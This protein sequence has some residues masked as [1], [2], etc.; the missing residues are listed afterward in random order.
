MLLITGFRHVLR[1]LRWHSFTLSPSLALSFLMQLHF[2]SLFRTQSSRWKGIQAC[3]R[4]T[5][6]SKLQIKP[7]VLGFHCYATV[8]W[9]RFA[10]IAFFFFWQRSKMDA[11][12]ND[13]DRWNNSNGVSR[14]AR[15][16][17]FNRS[18]ES[19]TLHSDVTHAV[20][21]PPDRQ[22]VFLARKSRSGQ[23]ISTQV[24]KKKVLKI[25]R[26]NFDGRQPFQHGASTQIF[27]SFS[28]VRLQIILHFY[29]NPIWSTWSP[30]ACEV[31]VPSRFLTAEY[32]LVT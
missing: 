32:V 12:Q 10:I 5:S 31:F 18:P 2:F 24:T 1:R 8:K 9:P 7:S 20:C 16:E 29:S 15:R 25:P 21:H 3:K 26:D 6:H 19:L 17:A 11:D 27:N 22:I 30:L 28:S 13:N 14:K 23:R 4:V